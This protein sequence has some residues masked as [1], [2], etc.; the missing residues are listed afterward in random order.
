M[1][2]LCWS[3]WQDVR[4]LRELRRPTIRYFA[5]GGDSARRLLACLFVC[6]GGHG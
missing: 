2:R 4:G 5:Y 6:N 1:I 3:I